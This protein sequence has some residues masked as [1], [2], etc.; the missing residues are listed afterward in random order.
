MSFFVKVAATQEVLVNYV[1][2]KSSIL[3]NN[4]RKNYFELFFSD[5]GLLNLCSAVGTPLN[6][7]SFG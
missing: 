1:L 7:I 3:L 6:N 2:I 4:L 5:F